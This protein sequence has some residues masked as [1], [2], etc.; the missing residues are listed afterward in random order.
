MPSEDERLAR[1]ARVVKNANRAQRFRHLTGQVEF[2]AR[3]LNTGGVSD[4]MGTLASMTVMLAEAMEIAAEVSR[5][6]LDKVTGG[7]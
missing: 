7:G 1:E 2:E 3:L 5:E 4:I 6:A